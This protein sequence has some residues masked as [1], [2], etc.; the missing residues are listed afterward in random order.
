MFDVMDTQLASNVEMDLP[1]SLPLP[2]M[3]STPP[4]HR[5]SMPPAASDPEFEDGKADNMPC[6]VDSE[7]VEADPMSG[8][9]EIGNG[10]EIAG[11]AKLEQTLA[12]AERVDPAAED[13]PKV[14]EKV[15][16]KDEDIEEKTVEP[17]GDTDGLPEVSPAKD[18]PLMFE[19]LLKCCRHCW[20]YCCCCCSGRG[21]GR[22]VVSC[23]LW[24]MVWLLF[25]VVVVSGFCCCCCEGCC[26]FHPLSFA[27]LI[28]FG[29][30]LTR[31]YFKV[32]RAL[33]RQRLPKMTN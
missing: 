6:N 32:K 25:V 14:E 28:Q 26:P 11:D 20:Q 4:L 1:Q 33:L 24:L 29:N 10:A 13:K 17:T 12:D 3:D 21:C 16:L 18:A 31:M 8:A 19:V 23:G 22:S 5:T 2:S 15:E 9:S 7:V 27:C 30:F